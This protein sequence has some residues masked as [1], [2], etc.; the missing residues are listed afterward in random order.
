LAT[1]E[2]GVSYGMTGLPSLSGV[3]Y[4]IRHKDSGRGYVGLTAGRLSHRIKAH[5]VAS[6]SAKYP[7]HRALS[8]YGFEAF[9][10]LILQSGLASREEL[11]QAE[12]EW[13]AE[14]APSYNLAQAGGGG[15]AGWRM[16]EEKREAMR[17]RMLG[18]KLSSETISKIRLTKSL[19]PKIRPADSIVARLIQ[20]GREQAKFRQKPVICVNDGTVYPSVSIAAKERGLNKATVSAIARGLRTNAYGLEFRF[21]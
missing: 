11:F 15:C 3:I 17:Q 12:I 13:V 21:V 2:C 4:L 5:R 9:E 7:V 19:G 10:V 18:T 20:S 14:L 6:R 1:I 8:K 16:P